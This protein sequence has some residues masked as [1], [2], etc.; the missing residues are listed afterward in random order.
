MLC[1][2]SKQRG[3]TCSIN[4]HYREMRETQ[5]SVPAARGERGGISASI[6]LTQTEFPPGTGRPAKQA[7][8]DIVRPGRPSFLISWVIII[9]L[10]S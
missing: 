2:G 4:V 1:P 6:V 10:P 9:F 8:H 7:G 5:L 3:E